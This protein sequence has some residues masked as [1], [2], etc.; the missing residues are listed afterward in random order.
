MI[1]TT[2]VRLEKAAEELK[3]D[4]TTLLVA[5]IEGRIQLYGFLG[6]HVEAIKVQ[7]CHVG[8]AEPAVVHEDYCDPF[9]F[10]PVWRNGAI[11]LM[12]DGFFEP[13]VLSDPDANGFYWEVDDEAWI[14]GHIC[15]MPKPDIRIGM[16]HIFMKRS[17]IDKITG[18]GTTPLPDSV[19]SPKRHT[20]AATKRNNTLLVIIAALAKQAQIDINGRD[21]VSRIEDFVTR[22]GATASN[23]TVRTVINDAKDSIP[24]ILKLIPDALERRGKTK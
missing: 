23:G 6:V 21:A 17:D 3:T 4:S 2:Y 9:L 14:E 10:V 1:E 13:E 15:Y 20:G 18:Q 16:N 5:V 7:I 22:L 12:K 11:K 24:E 8:E 19:H